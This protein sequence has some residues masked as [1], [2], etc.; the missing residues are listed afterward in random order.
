MRKGLIVLLAVVLAAAFALPAMASDIKA[1]GFYRSKAWLGNF[2][3]GSGAPSLR[4][5]QPGDEAQTNAFVEQRFRVKFEFGNEN[6]KAVWYLE[7]DMYWGDSGGSSS[8]NPARN[9][10]GALGA[11]KVQMETKNINVWFKIPDTSMDVTVGLQGQS[12]DYAGVLYGGADMAGIFLNGKYEPVKYTLGWAKLYENTTQKSDDMTLYVARADFAPA[13]EVKLGLNFYF[14]QDDSA[15]NTSATALPSAVV[16]GQGFSGKVYMP[17]IDMTFKAGPVT[18]SGFAQYQTGKYEA[19]TSGLSDIDVTAFM[20]DL[21]GDMAVGPGKAFIEGLYLSGGDNPDDKYKAPITLATRESS[22]GGNSSYTRTNMAILL[23]SPDTIGVSQCLIGCSGGESGSD[24]G[25]GGRGITHVAAGYAQNLSAK[26]KIQ[27]NVGY[28]AAT[29]KTKDDDLAQVKGKDMGT[30]L[31]TR[32]DYNITKGLDVGVVAA[33]AF[34]G[35]FY[36][37]NTAGSHDVK[38]AWTSYARINYSF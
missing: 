12:D 2:H 5:D 18:L 13:K 14:L 22:P 1:S 17:G 19:V 26:T 16:A 7:S 3:D 38:D 31:N 30:E 32:L 33:Y 35:D 20:L 25:N 11:D 34:I 24:P 37:F 6:V 23:A 36:N 8:P 21:R 9:S 4:T 27:F 29:K 28:L 15:K 10:G